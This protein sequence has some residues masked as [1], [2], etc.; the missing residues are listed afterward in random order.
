MNTPTRITKAT[1]AMRGL[2]SCENKGFGVVSFFTLT[3]MLILSST[4]IFGVELLVLHL[5]FLYVCDNMVL[6]K[7]FFERKNYA[8]TR[9]NDNLKR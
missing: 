4:L 3:G 2:I 8:D 7:L 9:D 6:L 5:T 1:A